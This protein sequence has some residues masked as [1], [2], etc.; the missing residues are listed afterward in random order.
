MGL[1]QNV[2]GINSQKATS[3]MTFN[4]KMSLFIP[5]VHLTEANEETIKYILYSLGLVDRVDLVNKGDYFQAFVHFHVWYD[6]PYTRTLQDLI[7]D[8]NACSTLK[9]Y[10]DRSTY[11]ILLKNKNPMTR[12]EV[13]LERL[14]K[15]MEEETDEPKLAPLWCHSESESEYEGEALLTFHEEEMAAEYATIEGIAANTYLK[16]DE[17]QDIINGLGDCDDMEWLE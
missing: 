13:E 7:E 8:P 17:Y 12:Q 14:V 4:N 6:S 3:I 2:D 5:R 9:C 11:F 10:S 15:E 1:R 16:S